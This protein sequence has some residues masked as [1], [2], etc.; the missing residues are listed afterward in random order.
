MTPDNENRKPA[1]AAR[2]FAPHHKILVVEDEGLVA[3]NVEEVLRENGATQ[4]YFHS[5][6]EAARKELAAHPDIALVLLDLKLR[7]GHGGELIDELQARGIAVVI[8]TGYSSVDRT[9][10]PV[11]FKPYS[12]EQLLDAAFEALRL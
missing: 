2:R 4:I 1:Q 6:L 8:T 9:D 3:W 11:L 10:V 5:T 12:A 7:D